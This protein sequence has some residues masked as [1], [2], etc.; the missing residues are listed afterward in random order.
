MVADLAMLLPK[1]L[2]FN[3]N[4]I[5][6]KLISIHHGDNELNELNHSTQLCSIEQNNEKGPLVPFVN[7]DLVSCVVAITCVVIYL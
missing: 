5:Q 6:S 3:F 2:E 1:H 7:P 4:S